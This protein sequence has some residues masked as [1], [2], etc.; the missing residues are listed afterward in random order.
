M[1]LG[2]ALFSA[3]KSQ[4]EMVIDTLGVPMVYSHTKTG[5]TVNLV[6]GMRIASDEDQA[7]IQSYGVGARIITLKASAITVP[8]EKFDRFTVQSE[9]YIAEA[10][11]PVHLNGALIGY[12][13]Y[14]K[15]R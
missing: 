2:T 13:V 10:V 11:V 6:G 7:L 14:I 5:A 1:M 9:T 3:M 12:R 8:P 4:Y 15:G